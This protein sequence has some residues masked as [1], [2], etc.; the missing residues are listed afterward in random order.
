MQMPADEPFMTREQWLAP[1]WQGEGSPPEPLP[2]IR[3]VTRE[4]GLRVWT[5]CM[6][7]A[8]FPNES[9]DGDYAST[10]PAGQQQAY[11]IASYQCDAQYPWEPKYYQRYNARQLKVLY[12]YQTGP[13]TE[14]LSAQG[15]APDAPPSL[16][17]FAQD[18]RADV[19]PRWFPYDNVPEAERGGDRVEETCP[20][21]PEGFFDL[22]TV[23]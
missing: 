14:C 9:P 11:H 18:Y 5:A 4:E 22:A 15:W 13:L 6:E 7:E 8:G 10:I 12:E 16:E 21:E 3:E 17:K 1:K 19:V 20:L 23:Q 2:V